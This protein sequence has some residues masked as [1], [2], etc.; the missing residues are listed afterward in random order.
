MCHL[1]SILRRPI[2]QD[3]S[4]EGHQLSERRDVSDSPG[5]DVL[6]PPTH[7][8]RR[9]RVRVEVKYERPVGW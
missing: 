9:E 8:S 4:E 6:D 1:T 3:V 2:A 5:R 7:A